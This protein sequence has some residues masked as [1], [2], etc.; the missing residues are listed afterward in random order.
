MRATR[1]IPILAIGLLTLGWVIGMDN[2]S[3]AAQS[4]NLLSNPSF[5][6]QYSS[7]KPETALEQADCPL[8]VCTT[9]QVPSGWKPWWSKERPTDVNPEY[10][11]A[12]SGVAGSRV[13]S[14]DRAAQYFSFW[15]THKAGLRQTVTVPTNSVVQFTIW[16][17][18]WISESDNSSVS[19]YSGT[20]N[21]RVGIDPTGGTNPY[22]PAVVW[23]EYKQPFD[24]YQPFSIQA[25][26]QGDKVTVFTFSAP[27]VNPLSTDYGFK[28]NDV[29]WDDAAL[30]VLSGGSAP[31]PPK[32][33]TSGDGNTVSTPAPVA[34]APVTQLSN[35]PTATPNAEGLIYTEVRSGDSIWAVA[36]RSGLTLDEIL[37]LNDMTRDS[38]VR[39]GDLL[40]IG[41]VDPSEVETA[42]EEASAGESE[43]PAADE[44]ATPESEPTRTPTPEA[45]EE[46]VEEE[47]GVSICLTAYDDANQN[48]VL[49]AGEELR[50]AVA[51]TISDGQT[52][53]SNY[54][55]DGISEPFC[56]TGLVAGSY[57][58]ARS[59]LTNEVLT[60]PGDRA[61]SL[62]EGGSLDLQFGSYLSEETLAMVAAEGESTPTPAEKTEAA[63][64]EGDNTL[65][66]VVIAAVVVAVLLLVAVLVML[67]LGRR[68]TA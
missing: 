4:E 13:R 43:P 16:G 6:G 62:T 20:I 3:V 45:T 19:D 30:V 29:Y 10:K 49:D 26:S 64:A 22:G 44:E 65:T 58:V 34:A 8:G 38:V 2:N 61:V 12:E 39:A 28:H 63:S 55:T 68:K 35:E 67:L 14:G 56:I 47:V 60:T 52:V 5:E 50:E 57:R 25:Q 53:V 40:I 24:S 66:A 17:Q 32:P 7:Y 46:E 36:A 1:L 37:E 15:S 23:S 9:A 41:I 59:N 21:M 54:V 48:G 33:S 18:A 11:P 31:P 42:V 27:S 51:F